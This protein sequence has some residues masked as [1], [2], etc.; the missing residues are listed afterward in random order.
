MIPTLIDGFEGVKTPV[1]E[2]T[3]ESLKKYIISDFGLQ[4]E[5]VASFKFYILFQVQQFKQDPRPTTCLH[6][7]FNVH[8]GDEIL[9][10]EEYG[11]LLINAM[12]LYLLYLVEMISSGLQI[13]YNTDE[14]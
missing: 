6:S 10:Y 12:S 7:I 1:E 11:Y 9:S 2:V 13:I 8:T 5:L 4:C 3:A 14:V